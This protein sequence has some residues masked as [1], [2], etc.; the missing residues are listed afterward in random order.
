VTAGSLRRVRVGLIILPQRRWSEQAAMWRRAEELGFDHL[1]TYDHLTWDPLAGTPWGATLPTLVAA[2][3]VTSRVPLGT[4]VASPNFRHPVPFARELAALDDV[5]EGRAVLGIGAGGIGHDALVLGGEV[6]PPGDRAARL[7]EFVEVLDRVLRGDHVDHAGT[8]YTAVD[9]R[10]TIPCVQRPRLPFVVAANGSRTLRLAA[11]YGAGWATTGS[12]PRGATED[13][14]WEGVGALAQRFTETLADAGREQAD[15]R[16]MV[17]LDAAGTFSMT[18]A[19][20]F[21]EAAGR[22]GGL[23]FTDVVVHWPVPGAPVYDAPESRVEEIA[24]LLPRLR[25]ADA[26]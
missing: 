5:S 15:V 17:S 3:T 22:A 21:E 18:S 23:G 2:A 7:E 10:T 6:L 4:W 26:S 11:R 9:A 20:Y 8:F 14:W 1:W 13:A 16:R 19:G 24:A 12:T 25:S